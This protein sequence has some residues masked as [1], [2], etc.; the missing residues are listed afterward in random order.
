MP[1]LRRIAGKRTKPFPQPPQAA[2]LWA[3][4]CTHQ[5][6]SSAFAH[7]VGFLAV[8][9]LMFHLEVFS[10]SHLQKPFDLQAG[11]KSPQGSLSLLGPDVT[12][13]SSLGR[14]RARPC[15]P[16]A[17]SAWPEEPEY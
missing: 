14:G 2:P 13:F 6:V 17:P 5:A 15:L 8:G 9:F 10:Q 3:F 12:N 16:R 1:T 4:P 7:A 11:S